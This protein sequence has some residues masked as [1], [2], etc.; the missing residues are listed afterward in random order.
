MPTSTEPLVAT[1]GPSASL[2]VTDELNRAYERASDPALREV[3]TVPLYEEFFNEWL[4]CVIL[5]VYSQQ[6]V[7]DGTK[8]VDIT[9]GYHDPTYRLIFVL[10]V[11]C[12]RH[13]V[14][15]KGELESQLQDYGDRYLDQ[16]YGGHAKYDTVYGAT[17]YGTKIRFFKMSRSTGTF[18][19]IS[20]SGVTHVSEESAYWDL[21]AD[22]FK[23]HQV[24]KSI[25]QYRLAIV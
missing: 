11:E 5:H 4:R 1:R 3:A 20:F 12:K 7:D 18:E 8:A 21:K 9:V 22:G 2:L 10:L 16:K 15:S 6:A 25:W 13:Q 24:L 19:D 14:K 23:I 17:A